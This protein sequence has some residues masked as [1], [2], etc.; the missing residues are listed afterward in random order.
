MEIIPAIDVREGSCV[1]LVGGDPKTGTDYGDPLEAVEHWI[2]EGAQSLH[3]VDLDAALGT[4]NNRNVIERIVAESS[5]PVQVAGGIRDAT[6]GIALLEGGAARIVL[7]TAALTDPDVVWTLL[8]SVDPARIVI[9]LE[10]ASGELAIEGWTSSVEGDFL[11]YAETFDARGVGGVLFTNVDVEGRLDGIDPRPIRSLTSTVSA[12]V[13]VSGGVASLDDIA[14]AEAAGADGI[15]I[16]TAL[17]EGVF[18]LG[19]AMEYVR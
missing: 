4:G 5:I 3:V 10:V 15:V 16:G 7:G 6:T 12:T 17:Y 13:I 1:Q 9:A 14:T 2:D 11:D 18:T 8:D 19:E